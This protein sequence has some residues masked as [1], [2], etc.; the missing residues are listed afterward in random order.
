MG[1][2]DR[3]E[4]A[5]LRLHQPRDVAVG[6]AQPSVSRE[7]A[8]DATVVEAEVPGVVVRRREGDAGWREGLLEGGQVQ[9]LGV[10]E[11][12]VEI[13]HD[14]LQ[15]TGVGR[16]HLTFSPARIATARRFSFGG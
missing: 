2:E 1:F 11:H 4:A 14:G 13:E 12:A 16:R 5:C 10:G 9:R 6:P 3:P 7:R 8:E 15:R